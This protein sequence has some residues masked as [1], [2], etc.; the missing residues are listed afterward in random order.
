MSKSLGRR[1][2]LTRA[3]AWA[4]GAVAAAGAWTS[5]DVL[6]VRGSGGFGGKVRSVASEQIPE[7]SVVAVPEARAYLTKIDDEVVGLWWNCSHLS[8]RVNWCESS[9]EF[10]CPCHGS[11]FNRAGEH[12]G[13]PATRGLDRFDVEIE[14]G[15]VIIDT[16]AITKG[17]GPGDETLDEPKSGPSCRGETHS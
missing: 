3:L 12:R 16:G 13:G 6:R 15:V 2:L 9:G 17:S 1:D 11:A 14:D 4:A 10:E 8:C 7:A 5:W